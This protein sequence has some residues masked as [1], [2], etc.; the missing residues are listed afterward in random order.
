MRS[1]DTYRTH[2]HTAAR[3]NQ[4]RRKAA[5][6][7]RKEE[8]AGDEGLTAREAADGRD[9]RS[10]LV[11]LHASENGRGGARTCVHGSDRAVRGLRRRA[12]ST[13]GDEGRKASESSGGLAGRVAR[14]SK[15]TAPRTSTL[16]PH[17]QTQ[18]NTDKET[19]ASDE[20]APRCGGTRHRRRW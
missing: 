12:S 3:S 19:D 2:S 11:D 8:G 5:A 4:A 1:T 20:G 9:A 14:S 16:T 6:G 7:G 10:G 15:A 18:H 13:Q 17:A